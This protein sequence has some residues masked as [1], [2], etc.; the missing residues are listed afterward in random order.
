M[1]GPPLEGLYLP[2]NQDLQGTLWGPI[3]GFTSN[4]QNGANITSK[5]FLADWPAGKIMFIQTAVATGIPDALTT[6][7]ELSLEVEDLTGNFLALVALQN[8]FPVA[9]GQNRALNFAGQVI[10]VSQNHN[11]KA[12]ARFAAAQAGNRIDLDFTGVVIPKGNVSTFSI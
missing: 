2:T 8:D 1:S 9:N 4:T 5:P 10:I 7:T 11:L 12:R 6:L 3:H